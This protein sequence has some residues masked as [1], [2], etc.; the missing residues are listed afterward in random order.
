MMSTQ[1]TVAGFRIIDSDLPEDSNR[2]RELQTA[3][4]DRTGESRLAG[5][6]VL[7]LQGMPGPFFRD[8]ARAIV[9]QG[10]EIRRI[11]FYAGDWSDWHLPGA[12]AFRGRGEDWPAFLERFLDREALQT[13]VTDII[14]FGDQ[15]PLHRVA[16]GI[17]AARDISVFV[18]EEG[19]LRP[20]FAAFSRGGIHAEGAV[21]ANLAEL[22]IA[23]AELDG[24]PLPLAVPIEN[25]FHRRG[26]ETFF[27]YAATYFGAWLFPRYQTHR[28]ASP[29]H[30]GLLW[31]RR[32]ARSRVRRAEAVRVL[33][34]LENRPFFLFPL[35]LDNDFQI[36]IHSD[37]GDMANA[38][39]KV[40]TRFAA[41]APEDV[42]LVVKLHPLDPGL[43][44]WARF[45]RQQAEHLGIGARCV[46]LDGG[47][48][49]DLVHRA[50]GVV[51]VNSTVGALALAAGT[52]LLALGRAYYRIPGIVS[53]QTPDEFL[54]A[55]QNGD[56]GNFALLRRVLIERHLVNGGFHSA[57]GLRMLVKGALRRLRESPPR[58]AR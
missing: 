54:R 7:F 53:A 15:R 22:R 9:P 43:R 19:Y 16:I 57:R 48:I 3:G 51:T 24:V 38:I 10:G 23:G 42:Q 49:G 4:Q 31:L 35:Q 45:V 17:G 27:Y 5:R 50:R 56:P 13:P 34:G 21:P 33:E 25:H 26:W 55:P 8:L 41:S 12:C 18:V 58:P 14:L 6:K 39:R 30:E 20:D 52:P 46:F 11:H 44:D 32:F 1:E 29:V 2:V 36:R 28:N 37:F 47:D 40:L